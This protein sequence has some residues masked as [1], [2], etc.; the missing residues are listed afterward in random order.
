MEFP[1]KVVTIKNMFV[2]YV[3]HMCTKGDLEMK[4][5]CFPVLTK[6]ITPPRLSEISMKNWRAKMKPVLTPHI[7]KAMLKV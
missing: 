7:C 1:T 6:L 4:Y 5:N 3:T 2:M